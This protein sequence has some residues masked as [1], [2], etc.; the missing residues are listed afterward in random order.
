[1]NENVIKRIV[2]LL[3]EQNRQD[4]E[5]C[6]FIGVAQTTFVNWKKRNTDPKSK[7]IPSIAEFLGISEKYLLTGKEDQWE[8]SITAKDEKDI[9][10][11]ID[12]V[13]N[14]LSTDAGLMYDGEPMDEE[15]KEAVLAAIEVAERTAILAAKKKYTPKKYRK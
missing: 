3:R 4:K 8:P 12:A 14:Q 10:K 1:M 7:Y 6:D 2:R 5:L 13:K 11:A 15:S 9:K